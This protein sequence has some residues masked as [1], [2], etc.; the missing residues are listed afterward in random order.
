MRES[1]L[2]IRRLKE[3]FYRAYRERYPVLA[4]QLGDHEYDTRLTSYHPDDI[5][6]W[7]D[8]LGQFERD[9]D[10]I[11]AIAS[12]DREEGGQARLWAGAIRFQ[13]GRER[14]LYEELGF[15]AKEPGWAIRE[16]G[17]G[18]AVP[19]ARPDGSLDER[20]CAVRSRLA[21]AGWFLDYAAQGCAPAYDFD[22]PP[23]R[24]LVDMALR[25]IQWLYDYVTGPVAET[26][27]SGP[28][29]NRGPGHL[30]TDDAK[31]LAEAVG[32]IVMHK[33]ALLSLQD[34]ALTFTEM[35][36]GSDRLQRAVDLLG[37]VSVPDNRPPVRLGEYLYRGD[38][39]MQVLLAE[40]RSTA[41]RID[42]KTPPSAVL[43]SLYEET[44]PIDAWLESVSKSVSEVRGLASE[45]HVTDQIVSDVS[46]LPVPDFLRLVGGTEIY[47]PG[48][49]GQGDDYETVLWVVSPPIVSPR[50]K[51][52]EYLRPFSATRRMVVAAASLVGCAPGL[53]IPTHHQARIQALSAL[54]FESCFGEDFDSGMQARLRLVFLNERRRELVRFAIAVGLHTG[55][56][57]PEGAIA[58]FMSDAEL[59][60]REAQEEVKWVARDPIQAM[61][62]ALGRWHLEDLCSSLESLH[63]K[64]YPLR[65]IY[66]GMTDMD[67]APVPL[68]FDTF[69]QFCN[70]RH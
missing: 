52:R 38:E 24:F 61:A 58:R 22:R 40:I 37:A 8:T 46:V 17:L 48:I 69:K 2:T 1:D 49:P 21:A 15:P 33:N 55:R 20:L 45:K 30:S 7:L 68:Y 16:L 28:K 32:A 34:S 14:L 4:T 44:P 67:T 19:L 54:I 63:G 18:L 3:R 25:E 23:A 70:E 60:E 43:A 36:W 47:L 66:T 9:L 39:E 57:K 10:Q 64:P 11:C 56:I 27:C 6:V 13:I 42:K 29:S 35:R 62:P 65:A 50:R 41:H 26:L 31:R 5:G 12:W 53:P 59:E 51:V